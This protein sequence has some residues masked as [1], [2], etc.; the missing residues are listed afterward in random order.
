[1][2]QLLAKSLLASHKQL[3]G[4]ICTKRIVC[5]LRRLVAGS[6]L[7]Q[8]PGLGARQEMPST[9]LAVWLDFSLWF[10]SARMAAVVQAGSF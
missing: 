1:M 5:Q 3:G 9:C 10:Q 8:E 7:K 2:W 6:S 4:C